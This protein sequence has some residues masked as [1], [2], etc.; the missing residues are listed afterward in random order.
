VTDFAELR[1]MLTCVADKPDQPAEGALLARAMIRER[2][3]AREAAKRAGISEGRWRQIVSG[4][5]SAK[6]QHI[7]VVAPAA[8]LAHMAH[9]LNIKPEELTT[10]GRADAADVLSDLLSNP[11]G[12]SLAVPKVVQALADAANNSRQSEA[13][14]RVM[15]NPNLSDTDKKKIVRLLLAEQEAFER[16]RVAR[17]DELARLFEGDG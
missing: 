8:T 15:E 17:A 10:A 13:L 11:S 9:A 12:T 2:L 4:Y 14:I 3:S 16:G 6:G 1:T 5:Q 7:P